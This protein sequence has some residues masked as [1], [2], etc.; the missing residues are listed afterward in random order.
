MNIVYAL[1]LVLA[2][3]LVALFGAGAAGMETLFGIVIPYVAVAVFIVGFTRKVVGWAKS[4]VPFNI[5]TTG[6]QQKSQDFKHSRFDNPSNSLERYGRMAF[7]VLAFRSLFRNTVMFVQKHDNGERPVVAYNSA[8]WLWLF[9]LVFHYAF[10]TIVIR[11]MR[12]FTDPIP[13]PVEWVTFLDSLVQIGQPIL[14]LS[15]VA[16]VAGLGV[17]IARRVIVTQQRYLSMVADWFALFLLLG[18]ALSGIWMRYVNNVDINAI[19]Q[20]SMGLVQ[21]SPV[22][23]AGIDVSFYVHLFLVSTLLI[24]FPFSKLMHFGGVFFSPSRNLPN[25]CRAVHHENPWNPKVK[26]HSYEAYEDDFREPMA[27]A[28]LPLEKQPEPAPEPEEG[29]DDAGTK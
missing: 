24:Y 17:L 1:F 27:E 15:D 9:A 16:I 12:F 26:P 3:V 7:E 29:S 14:Y 10:L 4:P 13:L 23:P 18:I 11:H 20:L 2:L 19:K 22:I 8:K 6:G 21:F 5:T 25:N 28:G